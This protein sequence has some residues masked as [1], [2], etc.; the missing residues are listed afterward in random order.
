MRW[1]LDYQNKI[2]KHGLWSMTSKDPQYNGSMQ[3]RDGLIGARI[4]VRELE[5]GR[6]KTVAGCAA[7]E[8]REFRALATASFGN[9][10]MGG[11]KIPITQLLGLILVTK[12]RSVRVLDTGQVLILPRRVEQ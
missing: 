8:F 10:L 5:T 7:Q 6:V 12:E 4:E 2:V 1:V 3:P 11:T 9:I